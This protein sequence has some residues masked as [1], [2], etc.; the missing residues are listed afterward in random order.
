MNVCTHG[1][2][3]RSADSL[4]YYI[5]PEIAVMQTPFTGTNVNVCTADDLAK[6]M[7]A[8]VYDIDP[9]IEVMKKSP[10]GTNTLGY[11]RPSY[12]IERATFRPIASRV[13]EIGWAKRTRCISVTRPPPPSKEV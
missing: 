13:C 9:D 1:T 10:T 3:T 7:D 2:F 4:V 11:G 6:S 8:L 12:V 5:D